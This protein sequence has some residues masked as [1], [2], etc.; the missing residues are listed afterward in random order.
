[1]LKIDKKDVDFLVTSAMVQEV[2]DILGRDLPRI[3]K[4][5]EGVNC[6][7]LEKVYF[8]ACGSPLSAAKTAKSLF[9]RYSS[10]PCEAYS[11]WNFLDEQPA[12]ID[13]TCLVI[14]ISHYGKT[15]EVYRSLEL[16]RAKGAYTVA[17]TNK[18]NNVRFGKLLFA[19]GI[20]AS[21]T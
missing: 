11:G 8:V 10:L 7:K 1:M 18:A 16:A 4:I 14:G 2:E 12:K 15:E 20:A 3:K 6:K 9:D 5:I 19:G 21:M 13:G 17:V